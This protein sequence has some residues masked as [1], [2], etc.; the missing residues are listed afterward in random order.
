MVWLLLSLLATTTNAGV[1]EPGEPPR[2]YNLF[3]LGQIFAD[4]DQSLTLAEV[5]ALPDDQALPLNPRISPNGRRYWLRIPVHNSGDRQNLT[6]RIGSTLLS[7]VYIHVL[8][9]QQ[10]LSQS[11]IG[12]VPWANQIVADLAPSFNQPLTIEHNETLTLVIRYESH[13]FNRSITTELLPQQWA[14]YENNL[15][16]V[17]VISILGMIL[18]LALYNAIIGIT[19]RRIAYLWYALHAISYVVLFLF[20]FGYMAR[21]FGITDEYLHFFQLSSN[22]AQ[23]AGLLF[24]YYFLELKTRSRTMALLYRTYT[25]VIIGQMSLALVFDL[26]THHQLL[27][28]QQA[29]HAPLL[30]VTAILVLRQGLQAAWFVV[31]GW[32]F[33]SISII[34]AVLIQAGILQPNSIIRETILLSVGLDMLLLSLAMAYQFRRL[35]NEQMTMRKKEEIQDRFLA[36]LSHEV[37]TPLSSIITQVSG[38]IEHLGQHPQR[39][40][41]EEVKYSGD[42]LLS[43]V[44]NLLL[45]T[46]SKRQAVIA[47]QQP[48]E[49]RILL[50]SVVSLFTERAQSNQV[51]ITTS[52]DPEIPQQLLGDEIL[53]RQIIINLLG[54]AVK[55]TRRGQV[56]LTVET[57]T[58][59]DAY[60]LAFIIRDTGKGIPVNEQKRIFEMFYQIDTN[61]SEGSAGM[62]L[63]IVSQLVDVLGG[64]LQLESAPGVGTTIKVRLP[65]KRPQ[66]TTTAPLPSGTLAAT[67][68]LLIEDDTTFCQ[69]VSTM[70]LPQGIEVIHAGTAEQALCSLQQRAP[71]FILAD[72]HLPD[73][74]GA[75]LAR[76]LQQQA[77]Q[78]QPPAPLL[79]MTASTNPLLHE[80]LQEIAI[81]DILIKPFSANTLLTTLL[82]LQHMDKPAPA[83]TDILDMLIDHELLASHRA[84]LGE[85]ALQELLDR[86]ARTMPDYLHR[87]DEALTSSDDHAARNMTHKIAGL[88]AS[89]G[90]CG[91]GTLATH[92]EDKLPELPDQERRALAARLYQ[93]HQSSLKSA[94]D[95]LTS[96]QQDI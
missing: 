18:V 52:I 69:L 92:M 37:R 87:L 47:R 75:E 30:L 89:L 3:S 43:M 32:S 91:V 93:T 17:Y 35:E 21:F 36:T 83:P 33:I 22:A 55:Y 51:S 71:D 16:T 70:L 20:I 13:R 63:Y 46:R 7:H 15:A 24:I 39:R 64:S 48:F 60:E 27:A 8:K 65:F 11:H 50:Q 53:L 86:Y 26:Y 94:R 45:F 79:I 4:P 23:V 61:T 44:D 59:S 90:F 42:A 72:L 82:C 74:S 95:L 6:I 10:L 14:V 31:F 84:A 40:A 28:F 56:S 58:A 57:L 96:S 29:L 41:L 88:S 78:C 62:G 2:R 85:V 49:P 68:L 54:N 1:L 80:A 73:G 34:W 77:S 76:L 66:P 12:A 81:A 19:T 5:L 67:R 25:L 38:S 9:D